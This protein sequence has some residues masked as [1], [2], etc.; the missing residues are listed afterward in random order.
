MYLF[1]LIFRVI[2]LLFNFWKNSLFNFFGNCWLICI[3]YICFAWVRFTN[4]NY[5]FE[6]WCDY[7][8]LSTEK[9]PWLFLIFEIE[10]FCLLRLIFEFFSNSETWRFLPILNWANRLVSRNWYFSYVPIFKLVAMLF[11]RRCNRL[12]LHIRFVCWQTLMVLLIRYFFNPETWFWWTW[13]L[14]RIF[15]YVHKQL[16]LPFA[17]VSFVRRLLLLVWVVAWAAL[18]IHLFYLWR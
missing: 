14:W 4:F 15:I 5:R 18:I 12:R 1:L 13:Y 10:S 16:I 8:L 7:F 3:I 6:I 11:L 17:R 9:L 2:Q